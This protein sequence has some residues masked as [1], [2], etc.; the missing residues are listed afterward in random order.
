MPEFWQHLG[1]IGPYRWLVF[2]LHSERNFR[3]A[4]SVLVGICVWAAVQ[5]AAT[6]EAMNIFTALWALLASQ[7]PSLS[8]AA[9]AAITL[10]A[11]VCLA[12]GSIRHTV[13][14]PARVVVLHGAV[15]LTRTND[16]DDHFLRAHEV[17]DLPAGVRAWLG[18]EPRLHTGAALVRVE[19]LPST[20][21]ESPPTVSSWPFRHGHEM[22]RHWR[23]VN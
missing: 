15:W 13:M 5:G 6:V 16:L 14:G 12:P 19:P 1:C 10:N 8:R 3:F 20:S 2:G 17:I 9:G 18:A 23:S 11:Q 7:A 21:G 22:G 4:L